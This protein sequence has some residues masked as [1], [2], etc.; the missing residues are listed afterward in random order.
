MKRVV[1]TGATS[2][3]GIA[4]INECIKNNVEVLAIVRKNSERVSRIPK[5]ELIKVYECDLS[6]LEDVI[7]D[8]TYDVLYHLAWN[9]TKKYERNNPIVQEKNITYTIQ[10]V[11]LAAKLGCKKFIGAGS[12]AEYGKVEGIISEDTGVMPDTAYGISKYA[13]GRLSER[14]CKQYGIIHIWA[15]VF[16]IYGAYDNDETMLSYAMKCFSEKIIANFS[17]A[18]QM[19]DYLYEEDAG[20]IF[21]LLGQCDLESKVYCVASGLSRPLKEYIMELQEA[22]NENAECAFAAQ[23]GVEII[24][25]QADITELIHDIDYTPETEFCDGIKKV[26]EYKKCK[27][28][29]I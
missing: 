15:R 9:G 14:L 23:N 1:V 10:A 24:G 17:A 2:M 5:S 13:A 21:Y 18:T 22:W 12:Q 29:L 3:I 25:L 11:E 7:V 6:K 28:M 8:G 19:W 4:L 16:S 27:R 26:V 20:K